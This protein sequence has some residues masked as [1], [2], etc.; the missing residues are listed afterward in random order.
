MPLTDEQKAARA[1]RRLMTNALREEA[2]ARR[3]EARR[4]EWREQE[5]YLTREQAAA[6]EPCHGCGLPV[7]DYLGSWPGTMYLSAEDREVFRRRS[8][9]VP[10]DASEL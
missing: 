5:M 10:R 7:I 8:G 2:R 3:G 6:G 9:A 1:E 4:R